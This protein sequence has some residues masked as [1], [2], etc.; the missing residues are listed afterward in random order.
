MKNPIANKII[1]FNKKNRTA[2]IVLQLDELNNPVNW[3]AENNRQT[4]LSSI[5]DYTSQFM[6]KESCDYVDIFFISVKNKKPEDL[7]SYLTDCL[8]SHT[9]VCSQGYICPPSMGYMFRTDKTIFSSDVHDE[10]QLVHVPKPS[11]SAIRYRKGMATEFS[12]YDKWNTPKYLDLEL[13]FVAFES[14]DSFKVCRS[15]VT[16]SKPLSQEPEENLI[17]KAAL[18]NALFMQDALDINKRFNS[19]DFTK[20]N[21]NFSATLTSMETIQSEIKTSDTKLKHINSKISNYDSLKY[22]RFDKPPVRHRLVQLYQKYT[23]KPKD[24]VYIS[25]ATFPARAALLKN[26]IKSIYNQCDRIFIYLNGYEEVPE[27]L[28]DDKITLYRSQDYRDLSASGKVWFM[29]EPDIQ[30]YVF[31]I[32]DDIIYPSNYVLEMTSTI[33]KY[34]RKFATCVHGSVFSHNLRWYYQRSTMF[35]FRRAFH[36]DFFVNLPGSGT[37]AYHTDTLSAKFDDFAPFTMVDL[38]FGILCKNQNVPIVSIKRKHEWLKLQK[39]YSGQDLWSKFKSTITMHTPTALENGPWDFYS[40]NPSII[41]HLENLFGKLTTETILENSLDRQFI[42]SAFSNTLPE[43][44]SLAGP[45]QKAT[46]KNYQ[47][48]LH[49]VFYDELDSFMDENYHV[50]QFEQISKL[51][52]VCR[53]ISSSSQ[54]IYNHG[55]GENENNNLTNELLMAINSNISN[56]IEIAKTNKGIQEDFYAKKSEISKM[57]RKET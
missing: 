12:I 8:E 39:D 4:V 40:I 45:H 14:N 26:T 10:P 13:A 47:N 30:G 27:F 15:S 3:N 38:I 51:L 54:K 41:S 44:W 20:N 23:K 56:C 55:N 48:F 7:I 24:K 19:I 46:E 18:Y 29:N 37:F 53:Q 22:N 42:E 5:F 43:L 11:V 6:D 35:P 17:H 31:L 2:K 57:R 50:V 49:D 9:F 36:H 33:E 1:Q 52:E 34:G 28:I 16:L 32:D 21:N 25:L